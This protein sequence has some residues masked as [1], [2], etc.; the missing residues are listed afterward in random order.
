MIS[1]S[2]PQGNSSGRFLLQRK[3]AGT[4]RRL[5]NRVLLILQCLSEVIS[6]P[7]SK[8]KRQQST[9]PLQTLLRFNF[10]RSLIS[11]E[12]TRSGRR[13]LLNGEGTYRLATSTAP[14][15]DV[16]QRGA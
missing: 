14:R 16:A 8:C 15:C 2:T 9:V 10:R 5:G 12:R 4:K 3:A 7:N 13:A 6:K 1:Q 11:T